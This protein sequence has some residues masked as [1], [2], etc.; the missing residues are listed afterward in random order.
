LV[1][2]FAAAKKV[3]PPPGRR[4]LHKK[5]D[6]RNRSHQKALMPQKNPSNKREQINPD[7]SKTT[8]HNHRKE[9]RND[10]PHEHRSKKNGRL[11]GRK[12]GWVGQYQDY[13]RI[14]NPDLN[15]QRNASL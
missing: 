8:N 11:R 2:F 12:E 14:L 9:H 5:K 10:H 3:T 6:T 15:I 13:G 7:T 1:T 4:L